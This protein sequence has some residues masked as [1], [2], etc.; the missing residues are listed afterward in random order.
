MGSLFGSS[1]VSSTAPVISSMRVQ[2]SCNGKPIP[3]LYGMPRV[4]VNVIQYEDFQ[5]H[6]HKQR[7]AGGKGGSA[8]STTTYTY[9]AAILM[10]LG[11]GPIL[12]VRR[13]WKG[14]EVKDAESLGLDVYTGS[15]DQT[16]FPH[17]A[18]KY[19]E[20]ALSYPGIAYLASPSYELGSNAQL[21]NHTVE[22]E[23]PFRIGPAW[24]DC[25][26]SVVIQDLVTDPV[27]GLGMSDALHDLTP[28]WAFCRANGLWVSPAYTEQK[29]AREMIQNLIDIGFAD[30]V[31]SENKLKIVPYSDVA[32]S[33]NGADY[34]PN[35]VPVYE[36]TEDDF[37]SEDGEPPIDV[38]RKHG[39]EA[40]NH[41]QVKFYDRATDYNE[42]VAEDSD[43]ADVDLRGKKPMP[44]V[45]APEICD[46]AVAHRLANFK[47]RRSM[48]ERNTY[49]FHLP[50]KFLPLEPTDIVLLTLKQPGYSFDRVPVII[51]TI[52]END[53]IG[54]LTIEAEDYALK[55]TGAVQVPTVPPSGYLPDFSV[56]PGNANIPVMLEPPFALT[57][58]RPELWLATSGGENWGGAEVYVSLDNA[59]YKRLGR[60]EGPA[61]H[62]SL[63]SQL[64]AGA[65][66]DTSH[67]LQVDMT[68][69]RGQLLAGTREDAESL[70]TLCYVGGEY[71][72][73]ADSTLTG[74]NTYDLGY[75]VRG[76]YGSEN[77]AHPA[78]SD[79]VRL[80]DNVYRYPYPK[81]WVGKT[82]WI[83]LVSFNRYGSGVQQLSEVPAYSRLLEGAPLPAVSGLRF[84]QP[85]IG[86]DAKIAWEPLDGAATYEVEVQA[87]APV[88]VVRSAR[89]LTSTRF[90]YGAADMRAD[91]G[92]WR[93]VVLRV[94]AR[95]STGRTGPWAQLL[96]TNPQ[97]GPLTGIKLEGG[98]RTAFFSCARPEDGDFAGILVWMG[99]TPDFPANPTNLVY[100]GPDTLATLT[101]LGGA[102]LAGGTTYYVRAAGYD[103]FGKD[104][105]SVSAA[106]AVDVMGVAPDAN[107]I[108]EE[109]IKNG[110]L[111][112]AKFAQGIEPVGMVDQLPAVTGYIGPKVVLNTADGKIYRLVN[113][114]WKRDVDGAD[115][116]AGTIDGA[117][118]AAGLEPVRIVTA[119][120]SPAGYAGPKVVM[121]QSDGKLYRYT[122]SAWTAKTPTADLQGKI[123]AGQ[124]EANAVTA[125]ALAANAVTAGK[126]AAGAVSADQIAAGALSIG[127]F[128]AERW[129]LQKSFAVDGSDVSG[130]NKAGGAGAFASVADSSAVTGG[131]V[132]RATG[133]VTL[134][135]KD[136]IPFD[137]S[138][139]YKVTVRV[140][141]VTDPTSGGK[142]FYLGF[143]GV[144]AD[145]VT[146]VN[147]A[148]ANT[149]GSQ[150]YIAG[151]G[152]TLP[153]GGPFAEYVG[154]IKGLAAAGASGS[155]SLCGDAGAPGVAHA[156]VRFV[157]PIVYLNHNGGNGIADLDSFQI[158]VVEIPANSVGLTHIQD[159]AIS[160]DKLQANSVTASKLVVADTSNLVPDADMQDAAAW[161]FGGSTSIVPAPSDMPGKNALYTSGQKAAA[162]GTDFLFDAYATRSPVEPNTEYRIAGTVKSSADA[163]GSWRWE[164]HQ[165]DANQANLGSTALTTGAL[166]VASATRTAVTIKTL[167]ATRY[168]RIRVRRAAVSAGGTATGQCWASMPSI[169]RAANAE[170]IVDGAVT[171][172]KLAADAVTA[173]TI[174][175]GAVNA[176]E[177]AAGAVTTD[178][179]VVGNFSN[180]IPNG[181]FATGTLA[182]W[183]PFA[184]TQAVVAATD[185]SVPAGA[186]SRYVMKLE[187]SSGG[188]SA[189]FSHAKAYR[190]AGANMDGIAVVAGQQYD[191][192]F[193][194]ARG[195]DA[196]VGTTAVVRFYYL[197]KDGTTPAGQTVAS[198]T[199]GVPGIPTEWSER[200]ATFTVPALSSPVE[201]VFLFF[202]M[203]A[204]F[205]AGSVFVSNVRV[206]RISDATLIADGA[207]TTQKLVAAAVTADKLQANSVTADKL[208]A[209]AVTTDKLAANAV[210]ATKIAAGSINADHLMVGQSSNMLVNP[211][212]EADWYG[213]EAWT[214][215]AESTSGFNLSPDWTLANTS[216][217]TGW[218]K[219]G[220]A[221]NNHT[222]VT[223]QRHQHVAVEAG[224]TY[225]VSVYTGA[226]RCNADC[227]IEFYDANGTY[228][229]PA[230]VVATNVANL[231]EKQGGRYLSDFKRVWIRAVAPPGAV[232]AVG[233][234]RK[235]GTQPGQADSWLFF[236]RPY[237]G[238]VSPNQTTP[239]AWDAAGATVIGPGNLKTGTLSAITSHMGDIFAGTINMQ[240]DGGYMR[241]NAKWWGDGSQGWILARQPDGSQFMDVVGGSSRLWLSSWGD[242]GITFPNFRVTNAGDVYVRGDIQANS[243]TANI[244]N[245]PHLV[246]NAV[247]TAL[248]AGYLQQGWG[249]VNFTLTEETFF[250][251]GGRETA[252]VQLYWSNGNP[253]SLEGLIAPL[254]SGSSNGSVCG[255]ARLGPGS[256]FITP[257]PNN[258]VRDAF[259]VLFKR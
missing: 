177:L 139:L 100:D 30:A 144:A 121:L 179:L 104:G 165:L 226:H 232:R 63:R 12:T 34:V 145:G 213:W 142:A 167:P 86:A 209:N 233:S 189:I 240:G 16:P 155:S 252:G 22:V 220:A 101:S 169:V 183:R 206:T 242:C 159:G 138:K 251:F 71:L 178:K 245:T 70:V 218:F 8:P 99:T 207:V 152:I 170:L 50:W 161:T 250:L 164:I 134:E 96:A 259:V 115:I 97:V 141:Q 195:A 29:P 136:N 77:T 150:H 174:A 244:V 85:W 234:I 255:G 37:L 109:M 133:Q 105:L 162:A 27:R 40:Y 42:Q 156:Q 5:S 216:N 74:V 188:R 143:T 239:P 166:P 173:G 202:D 69:S 64:P 98:M 236:V 118:F 157:R 58:N 67:Y 103:A 241:S 123:A 237:F 31:Y 184:G 175:A 254:Y 158:D 21:E 221:A 113:G 36:L 35:R 214:P 62:G 76:A 88:V 135:W 55:A 211:G 72:A 11:Q 124:I 75:L 171:A 93:T 222:S 160:T 111:T 48:A 199:G 146:R 13:I 182:N 140:R 116:A 217:K 180:Q 80:D 181:D 212:F 89:G 32:A 153:A 176:R 39:T 28:F 230:N 84:E 78:G 235:F 14:K 172:G 125:D 256:Y 94:R 91:G 110:A 204:G 137:P 57:D 194:I 25:D 163:T 191:V 203:N 102:P 190:D 129:S 223:C 151:A 83:K 247:T 231:Q 249:R 128:G 257:G 192:R 43:P 24:P 201:R 227:G 44:V 149:I 87:G 3:L 2:T 46:A 117:K 95:S 6:E 225:M 81:E 243:L 1:K 148:G 200:A 26:P 215:V 47:V 66:I 61:R 68:A 20:R 132:L 185:A 238:E 4:A 38:K 187:G 65:A 193:S 205:T 15:E 131:A 147:A 130:W 258:F 107:T 126:I 198:F 23:T 219:N 120:P 119:L 154:Y 122:G 52:E 92:P 51:D 56:E 108:T 248:V 246:T 229:A 45:E 19:P 60:I 33:G 9:T 114:A 90:S 7:M 106:V 224:R 17:I 10:A 73:Y 210:T 127:K 208:V 79:F 82:I 53:E 54:G 228:L 197:C 168:L 253:N 186:P 41:V 49:T 112:N 59:T 196:T 18:S